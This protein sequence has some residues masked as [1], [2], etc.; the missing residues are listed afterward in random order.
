M[1][2]KNSLPFSKKHLHTTVSIIEKIQAMIDC[3][4]LIDADTDQSTRVYRC[5]AFLASQTCVTGDCHCSPITD[6]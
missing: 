2:L 4:L 6:F 3:L 5:T 1:Q